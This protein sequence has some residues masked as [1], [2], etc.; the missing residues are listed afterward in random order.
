MTA[1]WALVLAALVLT[2]C[3]TAPAEVPQLYTVYFNFDSAALTEESLPIVRTA[4]ANAKTVLPARIELAGYTGLEAD[5][6]TDD[7]LANQRF[8]AVENAL[9]AEGIDRGILARTPLVDPIPLPAT[10]VRRIEIRFI[11]AGD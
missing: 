5:A 7:R 10:A 4:A 3:A 6:R 1:K 2:G 8:A 9:M 11:P